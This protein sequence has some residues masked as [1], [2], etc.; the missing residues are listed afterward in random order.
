L[1]Y[2][3]DALHFCLGVCAFQDTCVGHYPHRTNARLRATP[4]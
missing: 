4:H 2:V 1:F 3:R